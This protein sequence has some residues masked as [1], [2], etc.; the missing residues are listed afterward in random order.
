MNQNNEDRQLFVF[1]IDANDDETDVVF[2]EQA[3]A[4]HQQ[5]VAEENRIPLTRNLINRDREGAEERLMADYFSDHCRYPLYYFRRRYRMRRKLFLKIAKGISTYE[6]DPLPDHFKF[7]RVRPDATG[8][9]SLSVIMKC[10]AAIHQLA[11][12]TTPDAFDEY[13]QMSKRTAH[14]S[15]TNF[16]K[17]IISLYMAEYLRKPTLEDVENFHGRD[18]MVGEIKKYPTIMLEVVASQDLWIW[19]AFFGVA[20]ANN[21]INVLDNSP[22]FDDLLNDTAYVL[23][24][25]VNGVGYEKGYYLADGIYPQRA[26]FVKSFTVANDVKHAYFKKL[27]EGARKDVE[28]AFSVL[29]G[30]W[31]IIQQPARSYH[32]N[33][34]R[35]VMYSCI[36]IHNMILKDQKMAVFDWN[37][38]YANPARNMQRTWIERCEIQRRKNKKMR[39]R[40][41]HV[42]MLRLVLDQG[43]FCVI[44]GFRFGKVNLDPDEEDHSEFRMRVFPKIENLKGEHLLELVNKDV[45]L[46]KLDDEDVVLLR[47]TT[48]GSSKGKSVH[49][50]VRT[51][52]RHEVHVRTEVSRVHSKEKMILNLQLRLNSVEEKLKP[53]SSD[54]DHLDKTGNLSKNAPDCGLDQQ[55]MGGVSQCMN[56]DELY[57]DNFHGDGLDHKSVEG[58]S[59]RTGLNDEYESIA[60]DGL[61]SLRSLDFVDSPQVKVNDNEEA[62]HF[63]YSLSTQHVREV[64]NHFFHTPSVQVQDDVNVNSV[65]KEE[66]VKDDV[67]KDDVNVDSLV[68]EDI[69]KDDVHVDSFVNEDIEKDDVQFDS[70]VK[71]AT[72]IENETLSRQK[73]PGKAYLSP[74]IQPLST[75]DV[76]RSPTTPKRTVYV[77]E[78]VNALFRDKNRM[79]MKWNFPCLGCPP[80]GIET[81]LFWLDLMDKLQFYCLLFLDNAEVFEK[82]NIVKDDYSIS[83]KFA[84]GF[85]IQGGLY[86]D[87]GV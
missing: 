17:C 34:L 79:E 59:Q 2:L 69:K 29:Q 65:A 51:E 75:E 21:D 1:E 28:R 70:V 71:D 19:H 50:R 7:F 57:K 83:F 41:A 37:E 81:R 68:K 23:P 32:V 63:D 33:T 38:V 62:C 22:L 58:I 45:R 24:Y 73:F 55:S 18:N 56:V 16:N 25:V 30:R 31:G 72:Q 26:T 36:I 87:C 20:C 49:T 64:I 6:A 54:V 42:Y 84:D 43:D 82:K 15:L 11:Y 10:T 66:T 3:Y 9:M 61:I 48:K 14:D 8:R 60:V 4:Y 53:G 40:D 35:R 39:D 47:S 13:L 77:P 46:A 86:G 52:V 67:E 12:G 5:L 74:Y 76:T 78:E 27:Q 80:N 85:P 44:T